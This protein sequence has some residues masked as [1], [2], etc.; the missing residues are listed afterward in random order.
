[1]SISLPE[2]WA[3]LKA[4]WKLR[5]QQ[6]TRALASVDNRNIYKATRLSD[7]GI[8]PVWVAFTK[9]IYWSDLWPSAAKLSFL[10]SFIYLIIHSFAWSFDCVTWQS[11]SE[12]VIMLSPFQLWSKFDTHRWVPPRVKSCCIDVQMT[13]TFQIKSSQLPANF[14]RFAMSK[15][16]RS[17]YSSDWSLCPRS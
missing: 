13:L 16:V 7:A 6:A 1:M 4:V 12:P 17:L 9:S 3:Y 10:H 2:P 14:T 15:S 5:R 11:N 8:H